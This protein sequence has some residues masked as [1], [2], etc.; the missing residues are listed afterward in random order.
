MVNFLSLK[1]FLVPQNKKTSENMSEFKK[2]VQL[3]TDLSKEQTNQNITELFMKN[4]SQSIIKI[5]NV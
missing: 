4:M 2:K 3:F 1:F 5:M